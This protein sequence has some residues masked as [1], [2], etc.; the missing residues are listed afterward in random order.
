MRKLLDQDNAELSAVLEALLQDDEDITARAVARRHP[1]LKNAS[2]FTRSDERQALIARAQQ[3]QADARQ[4]QGRA[5]HQQAA[6]AE[7]LS[8]KAGDIER[9]QEQVR[10]LVASHAGLIRAVQ[11]AG[12]MG[13]LERFWKE[14]K[15]VGNAVQ[16][17]GAVPGSGQVV[18]LTP[19]DGVSR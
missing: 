14:Y 17:L 8:Q 16:S 15:A 7:T 5:P 4:L 11:L 19:R 2:A 1:S 9:L 12:G 13:A 10:H 18:Q 6:L 3:R